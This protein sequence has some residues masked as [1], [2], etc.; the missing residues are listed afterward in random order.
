VA[1]IGADRVDRLDL[2]R[3]LPLVDQPPAQAAGHTGAETAVAVLDSGV[4]DT[5]AAFGSWASAGPD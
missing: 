1:G 4:D 5:R 2:T 3:S